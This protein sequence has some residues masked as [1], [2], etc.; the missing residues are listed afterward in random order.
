M[1]SIKYW[2]NTPKTIHPS[3]IS[4]HL[5]KQGNVTYHDQFPVTE[6]IPKTVSELATERNEPD[7]N[8]L[9]VV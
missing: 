4:N 8:G 2:Q 5:L 6:L 9:V 1:Q 7:T 3:T